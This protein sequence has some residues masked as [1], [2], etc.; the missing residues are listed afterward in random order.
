MKRWQELQN[1][2]SE[3]ANN[4]FGQATLSSQ[5]AHLKEEL[6][7]IGEHLFA[8]A[9]SWDDA[10]NALEEALNLPDDTTPLETSFPVIVGGSGI[11][12]LAVAIFLVKRRK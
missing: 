7:E 2:V 11:L 1:K 10:A 12:V 6:D 5:F 4:T 8:I 9:D 3:W